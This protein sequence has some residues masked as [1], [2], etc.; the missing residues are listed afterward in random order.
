ME[1]NHKIAILYSLRPSNQLQRLRQAMP[2]RIGAFP[3]G[4]TLQDSGDHAI[5]MTLD[6]R[7][8]SK[9]STQL[10]V[11]Q[12]RWGDIAHLYEYIML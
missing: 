11:S 10:C 1:G 9:R 12:H 5:G 2:A 8:W 3:K 7:D 6:M 4:G